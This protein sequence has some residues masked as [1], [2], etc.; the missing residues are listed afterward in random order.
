MADVFTKAQRSLFMARVRGTGNTSTEIRTIQLFRGAGITGWRRGARVFGKPDFV[1]FRG[2]VAVFI[3]GCF[4]HGCPMC[5]RIPSSSTEFWSEK[6]KRN[7]K[8]DRHVSRELR[9]RGWNVVR[10]R[11][12]GLKK[13]KRFLNRVRA[14]ITS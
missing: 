1:F 13:P 11:E 5:K 3:D 7:L 8:R 4:W 12:C 6:I 14:L 2:R 9:K 10:A